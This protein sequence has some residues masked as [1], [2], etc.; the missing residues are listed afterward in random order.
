MKYMC[1]FRYK[2][3]E[4]IVCGVKK[5]YSVF[6][7]SNIRKHHDSPGVQVQNRP[8]CSPYI[9]KQTTPKSHKTFHFKHKVRQACDIDV[10]GG[11]VL[12]SDLFALFKHSYPCVLACLWSQ[13]YQICSV[14]CPPIRLHQWNIL[15][16]QADTSG[17]LKLGRAGCILYYFYTIS[18]EEATYYWHFGRRGTILFAILERQTHFMVYLKEEG[19]L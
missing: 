8:G 9:W 1:M 18:V 2:D 12:K 17:T 13:S 19:P 4:Y 5:L 6:R 14:K 11:A 15:I 16:Q 10:Y 3:I 7:L